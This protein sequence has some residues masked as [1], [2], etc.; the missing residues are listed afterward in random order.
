MSCSV[1]LSKISEPGF[2]SPMMVTTI[3]MKLNCWQAIEGVTSLFIYLVLIVGNLRTV[4]IIYH[5]PTCPQC[6]LSYGSHRHNCT[7]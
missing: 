1:G 3:V 2:D 4:S 5:S 7:T 6:E